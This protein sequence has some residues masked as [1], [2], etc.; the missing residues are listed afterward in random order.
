[1]PRFHQTVLPLDKMISI[2]F[3]LSILFGIVSFV[4]TLMEMP[5]HEEQHY[6]KMMNMTLAY[7]NWTNTAT[8]KSGIASQFI[9]EN[10]Y[11][12]EVMILS[13][14][15]FLLGSLRAL[16]NIILPYYFTTCIIGLYSS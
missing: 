12:A 15:Y 13:S 10:P 4:E 14:A 2:W 16:S 11:L 7:K 3:R 5:Q 6:N 1:M 9:H 8:C